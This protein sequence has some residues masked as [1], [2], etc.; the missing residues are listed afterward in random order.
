MKFLMAFAAAL[1]L[2]SASPQ[3]S[4]LPPSAQEQAVIV[5]FNYGSTDLQPIFALEDKLEAAISKAKAGEY[6]GNE[7]ATDGSDGFL[8]MYGPDADRLFEVVA[9]ILKSV[10]FMR[11]ATVKKRYGPVAPNT[12]EVT[13]ALDP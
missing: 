7:V 10:P 13:V 4:A 5:H 1:G 2:A 6:D 12:K 8:Y 11:G 9:P 3:A